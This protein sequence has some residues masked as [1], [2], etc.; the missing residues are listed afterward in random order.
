MVTH[1]SIGD[2]IV[3]PGHPCF[4]IAEAGVNH[5]GSLDLALQ[6]VDV[7][8]ETG[9]DAVK[10]QTFK[11]EKLTTAA[12]KQADYQSRNLGKTESQLAMLKRLELSADDHHRIIA[13]CAARGILFMSTPFDEDSAD[14]LDDLDMPVIKIPSGEVTNLP[15]LRHLAAKRRPM[16]LSTGMSALGEVE[17]AVETLQDA[18]NSQIVLLQCISNYPA[19]PK[20][21][22]LRAMHTMAT[23]F[24]H[25]VGYSD[26]TL[27]IE[28]SLASVALGACVVEK[29]FTLDRNMP[30]PDHLASAEPDE[31]RQLVQGI[32]KVEAALGT[33]RKV[34]AASEASTA[35][36]AR[37]SIVAARPII[38]GSTIT[39]DD[40]MARRPGT[41]LS[42]AM[43]GQIVGLTAREDIPAGELISLKKV[44]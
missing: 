8:A 25:P 33:G 12:A 5:N 39:R 42:P 17:T 31:I 20:D 26:H 16:I 40:L 24:G 28:V 41:G 23:A 38:A 32:R 22:N 6:L 3:G 4:V 44:A 10:F 11:A 15:F 18:G 2:R 43:M 19:D 9:A 1:I 29:H 30:G 21:V 36:V 34:A 27:G 13:R 7:A 14:F 35:A 37:R